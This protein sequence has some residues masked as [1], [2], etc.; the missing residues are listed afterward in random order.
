M[1]LGE[2]RNTRGKD[3]YIDRLPLHQP[4]L[5]P[6]LPPPVTTP[7][8][9]IA[10]VEFFLS[11]SSFPSFVPSPFFLVSPLLSGRGNETLKLAVETKPLKR[12]SFSHFMEVWNVQTHYIG[13]LFFPRCTVCMPFSP[14]S[15]DPLW[16][17][18]IKRYSKWLP[19]SFVSHIN[20]IQI[21]DGPTFWFVRFFISIKFYQYDEGH[22]QSKWNVAGTIEDEGSCFEQLRFLIGGL[23]CGL[24][25]LNLMD[26]SCKHFYH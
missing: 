7:A 4:S 12:V 1:Q 16:V 9:A 6:L 22:P 13:F 5:S 25:F 18:P 14:K 11:S 17:P 24:S 10:A 21:I 23:H 3:W 20:C 15:W 19:M 26:F 2:K 8:T